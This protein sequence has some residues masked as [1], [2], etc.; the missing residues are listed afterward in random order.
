MGL[1][2]AGRTGRLGVGVDGVEVPHGRGARPVRCP[3]MSERR[4][5][6]IGI[7]TGGGDCP[8]LNAVIRAVTKDALANGMQVLGILD[9]FLGLIE[10]RTRPLT[11]EDVSGILTHGG[12]ILGSS[13]KANPSRFAVG[14]DERGAP[15]MADV[16]DRALA[17][18]ERHR[19]DALAVVGGDGT[20]ACA[21]PF[22][23][24]GVNCIGIP[25]TIDNDLWGTE[26]TFG[27]LSAVSIAT[28]AIDRVRTTAASHHRVIAVEVM[29]RHAGW[30]ALH[31]GIAGGAD[32]ILLPEMPFDMGAVCATIE[33][34]RRAGKHYS[35]VCVAEGA[36]PKGRSA[37]VARLDPTSPDP[38][39]YG[40]ISQLVAQEVERITG[41]ESR[42]VVLGHTQRGGSPIAQDRILGTRFGHHAM[43]LLH[44]GAR[45]RMV[46]WQKGRLTDIPIAEPAG[47]QRKVPADEPLIAAARAVGTAFGD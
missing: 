29:G 38:V 16:T 27:F 25:K 7:L 37:V 13:N 35:I 2:D 45:N 39:R 30:I 1:A 10:D 22:A 41:V 33:E 5:E 36:A 42:Y 43:T 32:V 20:M 28:E 17:T 15:I 26:L 23:G 44:A 19:L 14:R 18:V 46:A 12:T 21:Q 3:I 6:R 9:G 31:A 40:G 4:I 47:K 11:N 34:R 8:G 24:A